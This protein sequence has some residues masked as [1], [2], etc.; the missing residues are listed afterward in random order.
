MTEFAAFWKNYFNFTDRT[1]RRGYWMAFLF[2]IITGFILGIVSSILDTLG[3]LPVIIDFSSIDYSLT[4]I[5]YNVLDV[6]WFF[7]LLIPSLAIAIRRLR[8][9]GKRWTWI[10]ISL[11]PFIGFIWYIVLLCSR[12]VEDDGV[13]IV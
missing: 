8:D 1:T 13:P 7:V 3:I 9:V 10:F 2:I 11:I 4:G 12:S 5:V 6:A